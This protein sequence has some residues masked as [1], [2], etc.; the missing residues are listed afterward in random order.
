L[1]I[2]QSCSYQSPWEVQLHPDLPNIGSILKSA[3]YDVVYFG[4]WHMSK[5]ESGLKC[6]NVAKL[7]MPQRY[8]RK[9][10]ASAAPHYILGSLHFEVEGEIPVTII[11]SS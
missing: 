5:G 2:H 4:K 6:L 8:E 1:S 11:N 7:I 3:G 10:T 9:H